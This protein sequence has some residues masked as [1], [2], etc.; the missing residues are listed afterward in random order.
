MTINPIYRKASTVQTNA[1]ITGLIGRM[2]ESQ[3]GECGCPLRWHRRL[4]HYS[5][6]AENFYADSG[7]VLQ[8]ECRL[9]KQRRALQE[10]TWPRNNQPETHRDDEPGSGGFAAP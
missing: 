6:L 4:R 10:C 8:N 9:A 5:Q 2:H 7:P 3:Y 1:S